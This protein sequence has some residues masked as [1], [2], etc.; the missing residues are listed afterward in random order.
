MKKM[1][2]NQS[3]DLQ[4]GIEWGGFSRSQRSPCNVQKSAMFQIV[5]VPLLLLILVSSAFGVG[6]GNRIKAA[7]AGANVRDASLATVLFTQDGGTHGTIT[8]GPVFG[9]AGGFTGNWWRISWDSQPPNQGS[10]QGWSAES[11]ISQAPS[12]GDV[13]QPSFSSSHYTT[14]NIFWQ[15]GFAPS[16]TNPPNPQLGSALGN[17]TWYAHGRLRE[18][19]YDTTELKEL[20]GNANLWDN[21]ALANGILVDNTP[22]VGSIAQSDTANHVAIVESVN[23]DGTITVTESSFITSI[24]STWNFLWRHRTVSPSWF[25]RFIHVSKLQAGPV[26]P[27]P[28]SPSGGQ[29]VTP[30]TPQ[31]NWSG[32]SNFS[33]LQINLSKSPFGAANIVFTSAWLSSSTTSTIPTPA[34]VSG[35][36]YRWD[37]TACSGPSGAGTCVTSSNATFSIQTATVTPIAPT[38]STPSGGQV[39][40][41]LTPQLNWSGGSNFSSL[42]INLSKSPFGAANIVFT[43]AWLSASTTSTTPTPPLVAGTNYRWDVTACSGANG[44]GTCTTSSNATFS[45]QAATSTR[46]LGLDVNHVGSVDWSQVHSSGETFAIIKATDGLRAIDAAPGHCVLQSNPNS[47]CENPDFSNYITAA[48]QAGVL[49]GAYHFAR[50]YLNSS[51]DEADFFLSV[52]GNYIGTGYLPPALDIEDPYDDPP[53]TQVSSMTMA[54]LSLWIRE[55]CAEIQRV[56]GIKPM[57]YMTPWFT[58]NLIESDLAQ[59]PLW[60]AYYESPPDVNPATLGP[61]NNSWTFLQ[62]SVVGDVAGVQNSPPVDLDVFNGDMTAL[63]NYI[64]GGI[65]SD[66][67]PPTI[68]GFNVGPSIV[69]LGQG[70]TISYTVSDSGGSHLKQV[71]LWRA[72]IDGTINDSSWTRIGNPIPLSGDGPSNGSFPIDI[73]SVLGNYWYGIHVLDNANPANYTDERIA[74]LGPVHVTVTLPSDNQGPNVAIASHINNQTVTTSLITVSG[75]ATDSGLGNNGISSVTVNGVAA[76]NGTAVGSSTANWSRSVT[77]N[78]GA[79]TVT[80]VAKDNSAAQNSTTV[81]ITV[82]YQPADMLG[83]S[84]AITSHTNNQT[85]TSSPITVSGTATDSGLGNN[86]IS[87]VTVNG[88]AAT[89]GTAS[90]S[91]TANWNRSVTLNSGANVITVVAKDNSANQNSTTVQISVNYQPPPPPAGSLQF[92]SSTYSANENSG[93]ATIRITRMGGSNGTVSVALITNNGSAQAGSDYSGL[94]Q[95]V[96]FGHGDTTDKTV[97]IPINDDSSFEGNETVNLSLINATGGATLGSPNTAVLTIIDDDQVPP[98]IVYVSSTGLCNGNTPCYSFIQEAID[99][100]G[101]GATIKVAQGVYNENLSVTVSKNFTLEGGWRSNF[102][103][104]DDDPVLTIIDGD[105]TGDGVG[106]GRVM[107]FW[108]GAG[109]TMDISIERVTFQNGNFL[110]GG[111]ITA[112]AFSNGSIDLSLTRNIFRDN[113]ST[114]Y[115]GAINIASE[116]AG[117]VAQATLTNNLIYGNDTAGLGAGIFAFSRNSS[118]TVINLVNN[119]IADNAALAGGGLGVYSDGGAVSDV[120]VTNSI[121]WGNSAGAGG[122][123]ISIEDSS[124]GVATVSASFSDVGDV[125]ENGG[126]YHDLGSNVDADP[127][128]VNLSGGDLHL[129]IGSPAVDSGTPNG[130]TN[131]DFEGQLR[132]QGAGHDMGA[133]EFIQLPALSVLSPKAGDIWVIG[134]QHT[135]TWVPSTGKVQIQISRNGGRW[136]ALGSP[137]ANDGSR[138]WKPGKPATTQA[139]IR[140]CKIGKKLTC[141]SSSANFTIQ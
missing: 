70:F 37:V 10:T 76:S 47:M 67:T 98:L 44:T 29:V 34:L 137:T 26:A 33:S 48:K 94:T 83:P 60:I 105:I 80:V 103:T 92:S 30:L 111:A 63:N 52:A 78:A 68:N 5:C 40:T 136:K 11:V 16:S 2:Q 31:L 87:S 125:F 25:Q 50:P 39:V 88:V 116:G 82:N 53:G 90:G 93:N 1:G 59:Y 7:T 101:N 62:Y 64:G 85:V 65:A 51:K 114:N 17:C 74:G 75:T 43:S 22:S 46:A 6:V 112:Y 120:T 18:L 119:T 126:F 129:G 55:W 32:G 118:T 123:D 133:D 106:D 13:P 72:S 71:E 15:S 57:L 38:P 28:S 99:A 3:N 24:S 21:E 19:G 127:L 113:N 131:E 100:A 9:T 138:D 140:I 95:V 108:A 97:S 109:V 45:T 89:G 139:R 12:A 36:N 141:G 110:D 66:T 4:Q 124:G 41:T 73:P 134:N 77:L 102:V 117:S 20:H 23:A 130:A 84:V 79:N 104:R 69:A 122:H 115:G 86:G 135:I 132:P 54:A 49:V 58:R 128:F 96:N 121:I 14:A 27:T 56:T 81:Q 107:T 42:Q 35:T 8:S 61:W 91:G